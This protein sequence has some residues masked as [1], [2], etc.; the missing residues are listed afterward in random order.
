MPQILNCDQG[1]IRAMQGGRGMKTKRIRL[2]SIC[3]FFHV[4]HL[5]IKPEVHVPLCD[6]FEGS[7]I[8][9]VSYF[10]M[11]SLSSPP[12]FRALKQK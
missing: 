3:F 4:A 1:Q 7:N 12:S 5:R 9:S 10:S 11:G 2:V 6:N 8:F